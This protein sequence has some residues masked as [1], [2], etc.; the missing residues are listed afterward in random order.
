MITDQLPHLETFC[1]A[2]EASSFTAAAHALGLTQAAV[3]QRIQALEKNL[4]T[5][6]FQREGGGVLLTDAGHRLYHFAQRIL[7]LHDEARQEVSGRK[8]PATGELTLAA[9]SIPGEH[10]L[11]E[12]LSSFRQ[13]HPHIQVKATVTDSQEVLQQVE[14]GH[15]QLGLVGRKDDQPHL[16]F[17]AFACDTMALIV[18]ATHPWAK[19]TRVSVKQLCAQPLIVREEGS[20]SRFCLEQA[21]A[22]AGKS[23]QDLHVVLELG[24][25]EAIKDAVQRGLG[26]SVLSTYALKNELENGKLHALQVTGLALGREIYAVWDRRRV[27]PIP[28][29]LFLDQLGVCQERRPAS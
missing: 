20:G 23:A 27:L 12:A 9:S 5:P 10:L 29:Q 4:R 25:N 26:L 24:S 28:A 17:H 1:K 16:E 21:L 18:P 14:R 15:T 7:A 6:L 11:P 3:S 19:R 22:A 13:R 8:V 2:A